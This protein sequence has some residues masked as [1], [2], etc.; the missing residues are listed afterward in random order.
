MRKYTLLLSVTAHVTAA[1]VLVIA[2]LF[3]ASALPGI[4][5]VIGYVPAKVVTPPRL[6][7]PRSTRPQS[8]SP[9]SQS[10]PLSTPTVAPDRFVPEADPASLDPLPGSGDLG[11]GSSIGVVGGD[12]PEEVVTAPPPAPAPRP[13][14]QPRPEPV[15][16]V[17]GDLVAP[18]KTHHVA[19]V[20]PALALAARQAGH[21]ILE[22]VI[23]E[24]GTVRDVRVLRSIPLLDQAA[25][26]AVR[27][28]RFS[29]TML[30]GRPVPIAMTVTVTFQL[31]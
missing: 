6:G 15:R 3:A 12:D 21:V 20:Y 25:I 19:P 4:R 26:D 16:R 13:T 23:S 5:D 2:P 14:L 22:A 28:W 8:Q 11:P 10:T 30:G 18:K 29:P 24:E 31:N 9:A 27:Q 7:N 1:L 17:G